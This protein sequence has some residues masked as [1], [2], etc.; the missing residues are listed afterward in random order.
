[1]GAPTPGHR[2]EYRHVAAALHAAVETRLLV[3]DPDEDG[4]VR[5]RHALTQDAVLGLMS[6]PERAVLAGRAA[7]AL[8]DARR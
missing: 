4:A 1:M 5:W 6:A 2:N 8:E 3:M 7:A